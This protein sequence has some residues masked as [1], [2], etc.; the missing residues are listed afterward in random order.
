[1]AEFADGLDEE[2]RNIKQTMSD[3][4]RAADSYFDGLKSH[5][6]QLKTKLQNSMEMMSKDFKVGPVLNLRP[7]Y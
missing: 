4:A 3:H 2:L 5:A 1:M 7:S 6:D